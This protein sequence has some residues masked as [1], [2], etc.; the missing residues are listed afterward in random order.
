MDFIYS[1]SPEKE[2]FFGNRVYRIDASFEKNPENNNGEKHGTKNE[3]DK[4]DAKE[5]IFRGDNENGKKDIPLFL[6]AINIEFNNVFTAVIISIIHKKQKKLKQ[7][8]DQVYA[9]EQE[10]ED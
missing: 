4:E 10:E 5:H 8:V 3:K 1:R 9:T 2:Q 7:C 6:N